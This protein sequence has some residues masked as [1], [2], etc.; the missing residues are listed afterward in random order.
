MARWTS[1]EH[2]AREAAKQALDEGASRDAAAEILSGVF[3]DEAPEVARK[4]AEAD[5][6]K[7]EKVKNNPGMYRRHAETCKRPEKGCGCPYVVV[8]KAGSKQHKQMFPTLDLAREHKRGIGPGQASR[9]PLSRETVAGYYEGWIGNYRGRTTRG[10]QDATTRD[11]RISFEHHVLPLAIAQTK[12]RDLTPRGVRDWFVQLEKRD[13]SP[14]TIKRA[15]IALRVMLACAVE[16]DEITSNPAA[17]ARY[18]PTEAARAKHAKPEPRR[19]GEADVN[20]I[21]RAMPEQWQ[22]FFCTLAET[23]VRIGELLGLTWGNVHLGD[24]PHIMVA[25][26][27]YKGKRKRLKTDASKAPVPLSSKMASWLAELRPENVA[28]SVPVFPSETGGPLNYGNVYHRVLRPALIDA[29]IAKQT[30]TKT[31][32]KRGKDVEVPVWDYQRVA[33]HAFR[34]TCGSILHEKGGT[35]AQIQA[36]L[37]HADLTTTMGYT[38]TGDEGMGDADLF[39]EVFDIEGLR[40]GQRGNPGATEHPETAANP[41]PADTPETVS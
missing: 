2:Q 20:A 41:V 6:R 8:W 18:I 30:G 16:D 37:R 33:F 22:A 11:Y 29:G 13:A 3:G 28:G 31:V 34:H 27:V 9:R 10:V 7:L 4:I 23:G 26:Q 40:S 1:E 32:R 15:R 17:D 5:K 35:L 14:A 38:H 25:E 39:D 36:R 21:L 19:L 12:L 24:D